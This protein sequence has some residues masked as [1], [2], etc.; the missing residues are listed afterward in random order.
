LQEWIPEA[1]PLYES[2][3]QRTEDEVLPEL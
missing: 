1:M 2:S 3:K